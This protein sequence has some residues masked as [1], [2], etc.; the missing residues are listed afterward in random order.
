MVTV[1]FR[2]SELGAV[3]LP[4]FHMETWQ[5]LLAR[6]VAEDRLTPDSVLA[7]RRGQVLRADDL[8]SDGDRIEVFPALSGG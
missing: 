7:V 6:C 8:I 1:H 5:V 3:E 4:Y 2:M